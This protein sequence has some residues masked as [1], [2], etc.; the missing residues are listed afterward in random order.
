M[1]VVVVEEEVGVEA[2]AEDLLLKRCEVLTVCVGVEDEAV[3]GEAEVGTCS[4][5]SP[6]P[7]CKWALELSGEVPTHCLGR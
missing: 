6:A 4:F 3:R 7:E 5:D 2:E 1:V